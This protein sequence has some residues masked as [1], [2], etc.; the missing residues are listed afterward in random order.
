MN[1]LFKITVVALAI[2]VVGALENRQPLSSITQIAQAQ[3]AGNYNLIPLKLPLTADVELK[4]GSSLTGQV[5]AFD[6]KQQTMEVSRS[7]DSRLLQFGQIQRVSFK[8]D[9]LFYRSNG[10][11]VIRGEDNAQAQQRAWS[12]IP[13]DAFVLLDPKLGQASVDLA[14]VM[15]RKQLRQIHSVSVKSDYVVDE[16]E[17]KPVQKMTIKVTP[18]DRPS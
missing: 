14:G 8:P 16:I 7:G 17:F 3:Q 12:G 4:D 10:Q 11:L 5:T 2:A 6:P 15:E 13:L 9:A 1:F 18:S